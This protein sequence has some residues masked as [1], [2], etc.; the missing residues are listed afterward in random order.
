[1]DIKIHSTKEDQKLQSDYTDKISIESRGCC[2]GL[3]ICSAQ[4]V[5]LLEGVTLLESVCHC[6]CGLQD[7][8]SSYMEVSL[9][10]AAFR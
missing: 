9:T 3:Y 2:N 7:T 6:G 4:G 1:M 8:H 10:L 5:K